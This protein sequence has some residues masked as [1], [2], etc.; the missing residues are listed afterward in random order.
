MTSRSLSAAPHPD[1][2]L[3]TIP[4]AAFVMN[5]SVNAVREL[6]RNDE[7]RYTRPG[8]AWLIS[9]DEI[10]AWVAK[11]QKT[12]SQRLKTANVREAQFS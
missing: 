8:E 11:N 2:F 7:L 12:H 10:K 4:E 3:L 9:R 5:T 6:C 1:R